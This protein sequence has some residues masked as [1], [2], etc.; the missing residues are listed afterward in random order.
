MSNSL[1]TI[2][3]AAAA[4]PNGASAILIGIAPWLLI[5]VIFY[6]LMIRPQQQRVKE[7]QRAITA[8]QKGD[9]VI[10]GGGIRGRVTKVA[11]DEVELEI[12]QGVRVRVVKGTLSQVLTKSTKPAND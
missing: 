5:F 7:H 8:I 4:N 9:E 1:L 11:D 12:A 2:A 3:A 10:T 6:V